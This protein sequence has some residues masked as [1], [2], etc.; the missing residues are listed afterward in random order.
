[1]VGKHNKIL[2]ITSLNK[3]PNVA[4]WPIFSTMTLLA[5]KTAKEHTVQIIARYDHFIGF[6]QASLEI[7]MREMK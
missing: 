3:D 1:M 2:H 6:N 5:K 4:S 7:Y